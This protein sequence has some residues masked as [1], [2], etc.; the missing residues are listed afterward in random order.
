MRR[1]IL[2]LII[3]LSSG[4]AAQTYKWVDERGVTNYGSKPPAGRAAQLVETQPGG[5]IET[6][7]AQLKR[8]EADQ[9]RRAEV[10]QPYPTAPVPAPAAAAEPVRGMPF[11]TYTRLQ[12]G[13]SEGELL[14]RA[15]KPDHVALASARRDITKSFHYYPTAADPFIT[16]VTVRG[17]RIS[18]I[19]RT[20][21]F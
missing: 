4:A 21:K 11:D 15:G 12:E 18:N 8:L 9:K 2:L 14:S 17:G 10:L 3:A 20:R 13:M 7:D 16:I 5:T 19:E 1:T 6:G